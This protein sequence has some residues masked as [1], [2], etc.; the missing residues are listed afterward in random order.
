M[1]MQSVASLDLHLITIRPRVP[2]LLCGY[3]V[4][5]ICASGGTTELNATVVSMSPKPLQRTYAQVLSAV[6]RSERKHHLETL[7]IL[8]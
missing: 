8:R 6:G 7:G 3:L 4:T 5:H 2:A 1:N